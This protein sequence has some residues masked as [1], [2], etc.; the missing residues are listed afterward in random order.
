ML[1]SEIAVRYGDIAGR[2]SGYLDI[3]S[4]GVS[5]CVSCDIKILR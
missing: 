4:L 5:A 1:H 3:L 2:C